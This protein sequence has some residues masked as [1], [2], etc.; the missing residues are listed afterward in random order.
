MIVN[1]MYVYVSIV[2]W[3]WPLTLQAQAGVG[4]TVKVL[5]LISAYADEKEFTVWE[6]LV[7]NLGNLSRLLSNTDFHEKF[8]KFA[9]RIFDNVVERVGWEPQ[10][11][12]S[13]SCQ[14]HVIQDWNQA[15]WPRSFES[16]F[17]Q[18]VGL[19]FLVLS[20]RVKIWLGFYCIRV[21]MASES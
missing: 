4:S 9:E 6:T 20:I 21:K 17:V 11:N 14:D 2:L 15:I 18:V 13:E 3:Q 7:G 5:E 1:E 8:K 19:M 16:L 10:P 12:E